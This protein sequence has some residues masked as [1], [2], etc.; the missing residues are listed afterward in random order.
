MGAARRKNLTWEKLGGSLN[1]MMAI[2]AFLLFA[3]FI[4]L[5]LCFSVGLSFTD[6]NG[7]GNAS[8][9]GFSNFADFFQD[10]RAGNAVVNSLTFAGCSVPLLN[11]MGLFYAMLLDKK[12]VITKIVKAIVYIPAVISP[13]IMGYVWMLVFKDEYGVIYSIFDALGQGSSYVNLLGSK[14][15]AMLLII[16]VNAFQ[17]V[18][19]TMTIYSA[20]LQGIPKD[21]YE[22]AEVDG[23]NKAQTFFHITIPMLGPSIVINVITNII[24]SLAV[25]DLIV[26]LTGGGPGYR[27][28]SLALY[29]YRLAYGS[30]SGYA[31]AVSVMMFLIILIPVTVSYVIMKK[32]NLYIGEEEK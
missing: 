13:L 26:S 20:G 30:R 32:S 3:S 19:M 15:W 12:N 2:P 25:F 7:L 17:Y 24:G 27:T 9:V 11:I 4:L 23:A 5:P 8:F 10:S 6:W 28:E 14:N 16:L 29:I 18:G 31:S 21:L 22:S 1:K